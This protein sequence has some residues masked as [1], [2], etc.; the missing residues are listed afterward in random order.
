MKYFFLLHD[1][2][3]EAKGFSFYIIFFYFYFFMRK[4]VYNLYT[5]DKDHKF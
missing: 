3:P 5:Y 4:Y 2:I 1:K